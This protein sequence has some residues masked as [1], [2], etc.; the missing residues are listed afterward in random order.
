MSGDNILVATDKKYA[1][2]RVIGRGSFS[3]SQSLR[4]FCTRVIDTSIKKLIIDLSECVSMDSTFMGVLAMVGRRCREKPCPVEI[5]NVDKAKRKLLKGLGLEKLFIFSYTN[6]HQVNW[7]TLC[8]TTDDSQN[9]SRLEK[10]K[11]MLEAHEALIK[12]DKNNKPKFKNVI[13]FLKEDIKK[14]SE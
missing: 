12:V 4:D 5:V 2:V 6:T 1:Q 13:E 14:L 10:A 8:N 3:C 11:T 7:E 9:G